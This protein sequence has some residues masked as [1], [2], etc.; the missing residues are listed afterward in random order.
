MDS[1]AAAQTGGITRKRS[2]VNKTLSTDLVSK[3]HANN[4]KYMDHAVTK[5]HYF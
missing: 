2:L 3:H 1:L 4:K 5:I